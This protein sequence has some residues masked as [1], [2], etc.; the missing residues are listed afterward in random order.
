MCLLVL[1]QALLALVAGQLTV[2][3]ALGHALT[4]G[5]ASRALRCDSAALNQ[6]D[7]LATS[8]AWS[9]NT[10]IRW[11]DLAIDRVLILATSVSTGAHCNLTCV[12]LMVRIHLI[13]PTLG[14]RCRIANHGH[15]R[16][17]A[18]IVLLPIVSGKLVLVLQ[19]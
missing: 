18:R 4:L 5:C 1:F 16:P 19:E 8:G 14:S 12:V 13:S 6:A 11:V 7:V 10:H 3:C 9:A 15:V 17:T 2:R